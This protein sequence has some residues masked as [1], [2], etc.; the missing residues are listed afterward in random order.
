[1]S[2][3]RQTP[4]HVAA[5]AGAVNSLRWLLQHRADPNQKDYIGETAL[6]KA[7]RC[8]VVESVVL[9]A[10]AGAQGL[11]KNQ[12]STALLLNSPIMCKISQRIN[13]S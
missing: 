7:S 8:G 2:G 3:T 9:L 1:M 13:F 5:E 6:H 10:E 11:V 4:L 12:R